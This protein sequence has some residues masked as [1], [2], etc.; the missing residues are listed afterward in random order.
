MKTNS[1]VV[2]QRAP[3]L[4]PVN[5]NLNLNLNLFRDMFAFVSRMG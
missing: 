3:E 1:L 5:L 2:H 4:E